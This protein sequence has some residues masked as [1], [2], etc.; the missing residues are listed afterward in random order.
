MIPVVLLTQ[1][2]R[3][4]V[5]PKVAVG[6]ISL[7]ILH[8]ECT[9]AQR[10]NSSFGAV[11][12]IGL[13]YPPA[14]IAARRTSP[15]GTWEL[16]VLS[17][18]EPAVHFYAYRDA[19]A[20]LLQTGMF[21][22]AGAY[23]MIQ[24]DASGGNAYY[25]FS[26]LTGQATRVAVEEGGGA[27]EHSLAVRPPGSR[28]V[29][30]DVNN[31]GKTDLL[32]FGKKVSGVR[33]FLG[34]STGVFEQGPVLFPDV[35]VS[36][37]ACAD[38]NGDAIMDVVA[39][40]WLS[41]QV[42][43]YYGIGRGIF[44]EQVSVEVPDEPQDIALSPPGR[45]RIFRVAVT[46]PAQHAVTVLTG[47][48]AGEFSPGTTITLNAAP[49]GVSFSM[50]NR[51]PFP[52]LVCSTDS[53][54]AVLMARDQET[55]AEPVAFGTG[56][57]SV[58]WVLC[59][60]DNDGT[61]DLVFIDSDARRLVTLTNASSRHALA[62]RYA[63]GSS[64][65]GIAVRDINGDGLPDIAV[66]NAGS[67]TVS[68]LVNRGG[69]H[70]AGQEA[71]Q[72]GDG[73]RFIRPVATPPGGRPM[74]VTSH[75]G[76]DRCTVLRIAE[77]PGQSTVSSLPTAGNPY[78]LVARSDGAGGMLEMLVRNVSGPGNVI[79]LSLFQEL[80]GGRFLERSLR[81]NLPDRITA[82]TVAEITRTG[83]Y[84]VVY[85]SHEL[86]SR[87]SMVSLG[88]ANRSFDITSQKVV[89]TIPDSAGLV[90]SV[91]PG[92][93]D[94][95]DRRDLLFVLGAPRNALAI[96]YGAGR[97]TFRDS[98]VW[99]PGVLPI[100]DDAVVL[101][102]VDGD[103]IVDITMIDALRRGVVTLYGKPQGGFHP[104]VTIIAGGNI[105][106]IRVAPLRSA[107]EQDLVVADGTRCSISVLPY[108]FRR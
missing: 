106:A 53:F 39:L 107:S 19:S 83:E 42:G 48:T 71:V 85:V 60:A 73:P 102:D 9:F 59:D 36:D 65:G 92:L 63:V 55:F 64:P 7:Q 54:V 58:R 84:D 28:M 47:S 27:T 1:L 100:N 16:A 11:S 38:L 41:N 50:I 82:V 3:S 79:S 34:T 10:S 66:A 62:G 52:D 87:V 32:F 104:P 24:T 18:D 70:L 30:A 51:D 2:L 44:S 77:E 88:L 81:S 97:G 6:V 105:S 40:N 101:R 95:D 8:A 75:A 76:E 89:L 94:N 20:G 33:T 13:S 26:S 35:S 69:G 37:L 43:V 56:G 17:R 78:V 21:T 90:T 12:E 99:I 25:L 4:Y 5:R 29:N 57:K 80:P 46:L 14:G 31:D 72:V 61:E 22:P 103:G 45:D 86:G 67:S 108:P 15:H 91:I 98:L 68:L 74:F 96:A 23:G 49:T 93:I